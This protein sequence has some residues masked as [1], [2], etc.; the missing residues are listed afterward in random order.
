MVKLLAFCGHV[1]MK[2]IAFISNR[3]LFERISAFYQ[4]IFQIVFFESFE[5]FSFIRSFELVIH[6]IK[7]YSEIE[8]F[9]PEYRGQLGLTHIPI[10]YLIDYFRQGGFVLNNT[11]DDYLFKPL[12]PDLLLNR[13]RVRLDLKELYDR[14]RQ[15][16]SQQMAILDLSAVLASEFSYSERLNTVVEKLSEMF[17][18]E[19]LSIILLDEDDSTRARVVADYQTTEWKQLNEIELDL[20]KYPEIQEAIAKQKPFYVGDIN[21]YQKLEQYVELIESI[22][23]Q[24]I[25]ILPMIYYEEVLGVISIKFPKKYPRAY[26]KLINYSM[27]IA[28][29]TAIALKN[30]KMLQRMR[31]ETEIS[32]SYRAKQELFFQT[33]DDYSRFLDRM[34]IAMVL[35]DLTGAIHRNNDQAK[36]RLSLIDERGACFFDYCTIPAQGELLKKHLKQLNTEDGNESISLKLNMG[37]RV[38]LVELNIA[39]VQKNIFMIYFGTTGIRESDIELLNQIRQMVIVFDAGDVIHYTNPTARDIL[40]RNG[41]DEETISGLIPE[42]RPLCGEL[43][44]IALEREQ[45]LAKIVRRGSFYLLIE[46]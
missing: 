24:A 7:D 20:N 8:H 25:L 28:N 2:K 10:I 15:T 46:Q 21:Q 31:T 29:T 43:F 6:P 12:T 41:V 5:T 35:V 1:L 32:A 39:V 3:S 44:T 33:I 4:G 42:A 11:L 9:K 36:K 37:Q 34:D 14:L 18:V 22:N 27:I 13:I 40:S 16:I 45:V 19:N 30:A 23:V 17:H 38:E 26:H